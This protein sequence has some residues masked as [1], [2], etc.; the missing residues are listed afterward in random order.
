M[1]KRI[2]A[3]VRKFILTGVLIKSHKE[4]AII[5]ISVENFLTLF[6]IKK[7][8]WSDKDRIADRLHTIYACVWIEPPHSK[9]SLLEANPQNAYIQG[10]RNKETLSRRRLK[11][12][13]S[14]C[15]GYHHE[16]VGGGVHACWLVGSL[17][18]IRAGMGQARSR[19][20]VMGAQPPTTIDGLRRRRGVGGLGG[21]SPAVINSTRPS[22]RWTV[23]A[24]T[25]VW[26]ANSGR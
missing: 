18:R 25:S 7:R 19:S 21:L 2:S 12:C 8:Y 14:A 23:N 3:D 24:C 9:C 10:E 22:S 16:C 26:A 15:R 13:Y 5:A 1:V 6:R 20:E 11:Q 17:T 4:R